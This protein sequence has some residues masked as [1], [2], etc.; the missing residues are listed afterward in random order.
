MPSTVI[1]TKEGT[2]KEYLA[3]LSSG[4]NDLTE[5]TKYLAFIAD[6]FS[7]FIIQLL[8]TLILTT[9]WLFKG[10]GTDT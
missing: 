7:A 4:S 3:Y 5:E 10:E 1:G 6:N 8:F 9:L 2:P